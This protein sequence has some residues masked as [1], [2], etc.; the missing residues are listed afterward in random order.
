MLMFSPDIICDGQ[1][2]G[3][4]LFSCHFL[5]GEIILKI[6]SG[7]RKFRKDIKTLLDE[8]SEED[9]RGQGRKSADDQGGILK[10]L[11]SSCA[12]L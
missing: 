9:W 12:V 3:Y 8:I 10:I 7:R 1:N 6:D 2:V 5:R 11:T 4:G